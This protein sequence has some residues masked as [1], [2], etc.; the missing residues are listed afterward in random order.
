M[1]VLLRWLST[2]DITCSRESIV[3]SS[4][5]FELM[6]LFYIYSILTK[7]S[8]SL[9]TFADSDLQYVRDGQLYGVVIML[10]SVL[11]LGL[12]CCVNK[13]RLL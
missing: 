8:L 3:K 11:F 9:W 2:L 13:P 7:S 5:F 4:A 10:V 6:L 1:S 12:V